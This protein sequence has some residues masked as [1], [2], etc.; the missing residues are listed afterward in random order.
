VHILKSFAMRPMPGLRL[1][2]LTRDVVTPYSGMLPGFIAG[3]YTHDEC[4]IDL[5]PLARF[6]GARLMHDEAIGLD[7]AQRRVACRNR[8]PIAYDVLS[9]DIGSTPHLSSTPGA[10]QHATPVKPI[11]RLAERWQRIVARVLAGSGPVRFVTV[12]GGAAGVEVTLAMR[13]RHP[14]ASCWCRPSTSSAASSTTPT[15]SAASPPT[16]RW[17]TSTPWGPSR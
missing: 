14:R 4:H 8:P 10:A 3:H 1:T 12:G 13:H 6:A 5:R 11:D 7:L 9:L 15:C 2:L 17:A 16:T